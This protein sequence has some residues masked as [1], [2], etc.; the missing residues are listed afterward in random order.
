MGKS[1]AGGEDMFTKIAQDIAAGNPCA[2]YCN[3]EKANS[4]SD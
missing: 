2:E 1:A 3:T 4:K